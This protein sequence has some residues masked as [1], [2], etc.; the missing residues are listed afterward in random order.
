MSWYIR[1]TV[2]RV[3]Y[4]KVLTIERDS[5]HYAP[6]SEY[7]TISNVLQIKHDPKDQAKTLILNICTFTNK[8]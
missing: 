4:S 8:D 1:P 7:S 5:T 6:L 3:T 2:A